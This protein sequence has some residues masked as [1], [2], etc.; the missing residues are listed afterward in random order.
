M[1]SE[2]RAATRRTTS[3]PAGS[4]PGSS[5]TSCLNAPASLAP[6]SFSGASAQAPDDL[7][8]DLRKDLSTAIALL[9]RLP[10]RVGS[11]A[12]G[13]MRRN[14]CHVQAGIPQ[15]DVRDL[16]PECQVRA[17]E[18]LGGHLCREVSEFSLTLLG[19]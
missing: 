15:P 19:R 17:R 6:W 16:T 7:T 14:Y 18:L 13:D 3:P 10:S 9:L 1:A 12:G 11:L 2:E 4:N 5:V 8:R